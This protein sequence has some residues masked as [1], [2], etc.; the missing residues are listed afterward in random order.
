MSSK[1]RK[2]FDGIGRPAGI[3]DDIFGP[4]GKAVVKNV[5]KNVRTEIK[6]HLANPNELGGR[7][8]RQMDAEYE[9]HTAFEKLYGKKYYD[10]KKVMGNMTKAYGEEERAIKKQLEKKANATKNTKIKTPPKKVAKP[11]SGNGIS[12]E[13]KDYVLRNSRGDY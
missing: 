9:V 2:A 7:S 6:Q 10:N 13:Y 4:L 5:R 8:L 12:K 1:P 3:I 11:K